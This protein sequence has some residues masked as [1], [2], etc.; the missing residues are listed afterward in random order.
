MSKLEGVSDWNDTESIADDNLSVVCVAPDSPNFSV[1]PLSSEPVDL[2]TELESIADQMRTFISDVNDQYNG[3][4]NC[5]EI[6]C[7]DEQIE[8]AVYALGTIFYLNFDEPRGCR[9]VRFTLPINAPTV[10]DE[11]E[12]RQIIYGD[13]L[14]TP[15]RILA[16]KLRAW[17]ADPNGPKSIRV[18]KVARIHELCW[19]FKL[20]ATNEKDGFLIT[21]SKKFK[22]ASAVIDEKKVERILREKKQRTVKSEKQLFL[23]THRVTTPIVSQA[24]IEDPLL[25]SITNELRSFIADTDGPRSMT[26]SK[27]TFSPEVSQLAAVFSL[28]VT[29]ESDTIVL[30]KKTQGPFVVSETKV[31]EVINRNGKRI[32]EEDSEDAEMPPDSPLQSDEED[33]DHTTKES[34]HEI[35]D[36]EQEIRKFVVD[37][38]GPTSMTLYCPDNAKTLTVFL[39]GHAFGLIYSEVPGRGSCYVRLTRTADTTSQNIDEASVKRLLEESHPSFRATQLILEGGLDCKRISDIKGF[40]QCLRAFLDDAEAKSFSIPYTSDPRVTALAKV[41]HL[42]VVKQNG[43]ITLIRRLEGTPAISQKK[44]AKALGMSVTEPKRKR[45]RKATSTISAPSSNSAEQFP[46]IEVPALSLWLRA[47]VNNA[48]GP[49]EMTIPPTS[50]QTQGN[51]T[52]LAAAFGLSAAF[53]NGF[54][55]LKKTGRGVD[56][57][58]VAQLTKK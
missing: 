45:R 57:W 29:P 53:N 1:A 13:L 8:D 39:L 54:T 21:K 42:T 31:A 49:L 19:Q 33:L 20:N 16:K 23:K 30:T 2:F 12:V 34:H 58:K 10:V 37:A 52:Q 32:R 17:I 4:N 40:E 5:L 9:H 36:L 55:S 3:N 47:F 18:Q 50:Q 22:G 38:Q 43:E 7:K 6:A 56:E 48:H 44:L 14:R 15:I 25:H 26:I 41:F 51:V 46:D 35:R 11:D 28:A 24:V 27:S